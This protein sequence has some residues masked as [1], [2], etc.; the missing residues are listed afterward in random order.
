[1]WEGLLDGTIDMMSSD[2]APHT[3]EEKEVGWT[4]MWSAH[5]GTPGIQ[6]QYPLLLDLVNKGKL[7][8]ERAIEI[9]CSRPAE[10]FGLAQ[11]KGVIAPGADADLVVADMDAPWT[12]TNASV[13]SR[14]GWTPYDGRE[15]SAS[16]ERTILRGQEIY[17]DGNVIGQPGQGRMAVAEEPVA[18]SA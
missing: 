4:K 9:V 8:L 14:C 7:S 11:T 18:A 5:T 6:Y 15:C 16:I 13:L 12:I 10:V 1:V 2:H 3:R 17:V